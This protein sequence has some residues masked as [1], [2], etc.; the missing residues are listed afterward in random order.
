MI[1]YD[2]LGKRIKEVRQQQGLSQMRLAEMV[3][4]SASHINHVESGLKGAS[5]ALLIEIA[6]ALNVTVD[7]LLCGN[8]LSDPYEY[9]TDMDLIMA[10]CSSKEKRVIY[11]ISKAAKTALR[12]NLY[13]DVV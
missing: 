11:E 7:E 9:L 4:V 3:N 10:D 8:Q 13:T 12:D 2:I 5:L 1:D 6:N